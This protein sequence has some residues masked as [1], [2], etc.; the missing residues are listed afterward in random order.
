MPTHPN[1]GIHTNLSIEPFH[2][3]RYLA[4]QTFRFNERRM[5]D[6]DRFV[7]TLT[8]T[9]GRRLTYARLTGKESAYLG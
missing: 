9:T 7:L 2:L 5:T 6:K 1:A 3:H 4:E 8:Q